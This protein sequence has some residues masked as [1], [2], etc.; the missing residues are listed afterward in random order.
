MADIR[1]GVIGLGRI[2]EL[3]ARHLTGTIQGARIVKAAVAPEDLAAMRSAA[4]GG[5]K[6]RPYPL[7]DSVE[8]LVNDPG[9]D[10]VVIASP[11]SLHRAHIELAARAGKAIFCEKPIADSLE[12]SRQVAEVVRRSGVPF[13]VGF[14]RRY[15][16]SYA[17]AKALIEE[18]RIGEPE[19]FRGISTDKM[20]PVSFLKTSGGL[21]FDLGIH[22]FDAAR[23][24]MNDEVVAVHATGNVLV[25]PALAEFDDVDYGVVTLRFSRGGL[26]VVQNAWR[27]PYGYD[28]R[29]EVHGSKGKVVAE[30]DVRWPT[31][32]YGEQGVIGERYFLFTERFQEAYRRELQAFVDA[33]RRDTPPTPNLED[34]IK[35]LEI[36]HAATLSRRTNQWVTV[37]FSS[38]DEGVQT[39]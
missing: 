36:A 2:G 21:F 15:D 4:G 32:L 27:A 1:I 28:V 20:P 23:F 11:S 8:E 10:A 35:A 7:T 14:Q 9:I 25:E 13:Q 31:Y 16:P 39:A 6:E 37:D 33:L 38:P 30:V 19:M 17:R 5:E 22:D 34:G 29:A 18:G 12:A 24:L 3:H 26:G